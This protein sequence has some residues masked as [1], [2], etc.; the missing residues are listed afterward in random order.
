VYAIPYVP[1]HVL[2]TD[3]LL[4]G[5]SALRI[6]FLATLYP[7]RSAARLNPVEALRYE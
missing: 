3:V 5:F 2:Y 4:V 6:S 1:F 7:A